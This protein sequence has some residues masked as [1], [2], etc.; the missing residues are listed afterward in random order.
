LITSPACRGEKRVP[1]SAI[2]AVCG[3]SRFALHR[4]LWTGRASEDLCTVLTRLARA[5]EAG[6][7][8]LK[9]TGR[10]GDRPKRWEIIEQ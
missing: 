5:H 4:V 8:R 2:A 7:L 6:K 9:R 3:L 1:L 10:H